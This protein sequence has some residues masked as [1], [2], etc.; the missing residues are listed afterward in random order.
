VTEHPPPPQNYLVHTIA[1]SAVLIA[2][3]V[4]FLVKVWG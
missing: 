4:A 2:V 3:M 1:I